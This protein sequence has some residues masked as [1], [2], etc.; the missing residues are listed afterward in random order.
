MGQSS[1]GRSVGKIIYWRLSKQFLW[2]SLSISLGDGQSMRQPC[3]WD[4]C[5]L[6]CGMW[7]D[8]DIHS[9]DIY[10][11]TGHVV[12]LGSQGREA[13]TCRARMT[14]CQRKCQVN[15]ALIVSISLQCPVHICI[16]LI[17]VFSEMAWDK[18]FLFQVTLHVEGWGVPK[19]LLLLS[20][21]CCCCSSSLMSHL[22][23]CM[24]GGARLFL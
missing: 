15:S 18:S 23:A 17:L 6:Q 19:V 10:I 20:N 16:K 3:C 9:R 7:P 5:I 11:W 2:A 14:L 1:T 22:C 24:E 13:G 4:S 8:L 12:C 21:H